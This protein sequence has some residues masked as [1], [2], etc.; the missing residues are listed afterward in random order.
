MGDEFLLETARVE[1]RVFE[2]LFLLALQI[3]PR[4]SPVDD[5]LLQFF[6]ETAGGMAVLRYWY[7]THAESNLDAAARIELAA[8]EAL[9]ALRMSTPK[10]LSARLEEIGKARSTKMGRPKRGDPVEIRRFV[11]DL[12]SKLKESPRGPQPDDLT[13][14]ALSDPRKGL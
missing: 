9:R 13:E 12:E 6:R 14:S 1:T 8:S 7:L 3:G 10:E 5:V 2:Q 4:R 11:V